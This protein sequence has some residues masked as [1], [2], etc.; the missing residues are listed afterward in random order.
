ML[1]SLSNSLEKVA[2]Y[3]SLKKSLQSAYVAIARRLDATHHSFMA[4]FASLWGLVQGSLVIAGPL[5][6]FRIT[7]TTDAGPDE[8]TGTLKSHDREEPP[9]KRGED[10]AASSESVPG[11]V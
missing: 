10:H 1:G 2:F 6:L 7:E 4:M 8:I 9:E 11:V 3:A 5:I